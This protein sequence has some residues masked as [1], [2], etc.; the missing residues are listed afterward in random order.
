MTGVPERSNEVRSLEPSPSARVPVVPLAVSP[1]KAALY[2]DV[3]HDA[4]YA[5][6][7][8]GRIKSVKLGRRRLI[9][10]SELERFLQEEMR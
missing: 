7:H 6:L 9:P 8:A 2:L 5:L 10:V 1:R 4:I 3:G